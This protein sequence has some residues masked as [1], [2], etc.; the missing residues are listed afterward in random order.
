MDLRPGYRELAPPPALRG[1]LECLWVRVGLASGP[2]N[3]LV[4]PDACSDLIWQAEA[5]TFVA[6]PDTG[7]APAVVRPGTVLVGA[8]FLPGAG[9]PALG[10]PLSALRD[11]RVDVTDLL[12]ELDDRLP[13][14]L[15]PEAALRGLTAT[16]VRLTAAA[17][18]DPAVRRAARLLADSGARV[19][20]LADELGLSERQLRRRF[21]AAVG[22][23]P[24]TLQ[25]VLRFRRFLSRLDAGRAETDL[26][27][28]AL[29]AGY[30]DQAHLT[31]ECA[32]LAG[33]PPTALARTRA[34]APAEEPV[35]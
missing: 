25:R 31:R 12:P 4:L 34:E 3:T 27:R 11:L 10:V 33:F 5:G 35:G 1:A 14:S 18:P 32:R 19:E 17:P 7:P 24:K 21:H 13:A 26:A 15:T 8:R 30:A 28:I 16:V 22:Y 6:G 2:P 29:E 20:T 9:G 23:G